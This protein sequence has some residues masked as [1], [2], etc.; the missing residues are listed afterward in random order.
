MET[1]LLATKLQVP[2]QPKQEVHRA[3]LVDVLER[4]I[5]N[6]KLTLISAPAGYG[7][8]TLL[9]QWSHSSQFPVAWVSLGREDND[10]ESFLRY[11]LASW[12]K[13]QPGV[14]E[15]PLGL[16][17]GAMSPDTQ[18]VLSAYINL[19][20]DA[21]T[22]V[23]FVLDD[24]HSIDEPSIHKALTYL[25]DNL[26]PTLRFVLAGR[27]EPPLPLARYRAH[28]EMM[29]L[30]T[31]D[32]RFTREET[33]AF[34]NGMLGRDL[35]PEELE[36]LQAQL[37]G[38]V[39]GLKLAALEVRQRHEGT[40]RAVVSGRHRYIADYLTEDVLAHLPDDLQSFLLETCILDR[41]CASL[42]DAVTGQKHGQTMLE[43]LERKDLFLVPLDDHREWYRYHHLFADFLNEELHRRFPAKVA[44]VHQRAA[45]WYLGFDLPRQAFQHAVAGKDVHQVVQIV[46]RYVPVKLLTGQIRVVEQWLEGIPALWY[47][48]YPTLQLAEG[49]FL[50]ITGSI[51]DCVRRLDEVE[52]RLGS[53]DSEEI[54]W[55]LARIAACRCLIACLQNDVE[56]A[57][58]YAFQAM[59]DLRESQD[60]FFRAGIHHALGDLYR[61]NARWADAQARYLEVL[62]LAE[63]PLVS[64]RKAHIYGALADLDFRRGHLKG[65]AAYWREAL[66]SIQEP[67]RQEHVPLPVT[68][69]V[70]IRMAE[71]HYE[72]NELAKAGDYLS[73]GLERAELAGDVRAM[74]AGYLIAGRL[75][76]TEGNTAAAADYVEQTHPLVESAQFAHWTSRFER[77][78]LELWLAQGRLRTAVDWSDE[79]LEDDT[80]KE[81]PESEIAQLAIARVLIVKGDRP[82]LEGALALLES[83]VRRAEAEGR[84]GVTIEG[85]ALVA[86]ARWSAGDLLEAMTALERAL[87][88]AEP[89]GYVRRFADLGRPMAGLL[90][91]ARSRAVMSAYVE[92][93]LTALEGA[94][95]FRVPKQ[96]ALLEPLTDREQDVLELLAAGL[97]NPEIADALVISPGT[98]KTHARNIYGKLDVGNRT[99]AAARAREL[100]LLG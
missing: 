89:Q 73:R 69:W 55:Q 16:L 14:D 47:E 22:P 96:K 68:G 60:V 76:L 87:R 93:L 18:A 11:L 35:G 12:E 41:L 72:W 9:S 10:L 51:D 59:R 17:L 48:S 78:Q 90:H 53:L 66:A 75:E 28:G 39:A 52:G 37:E 32:L 49:F 61:Q 84:E 23:A 34:M 95:G 63:D 46:E 74:I 85:L 36:P 43:T 1:F 24:Y 86:L 19:A 97:T 56:R 82:S 20:N 30:G 3:R 62:D 71:I 25:L 6:H 26:P 99:E 4:D 83:L 7:K 88:L 64:F 50:A 58:S 2:P 40:E 31:A 29:A 33:A 27:G 80:L 44:E 15:S 67:E 94:D 21:T 98:V 100:E 79:M 57:E 13:V 54:R 65:A 92:V 38:W 70:Y 77:L 91:E 45:R 8:S 5:P 42:C 81:R